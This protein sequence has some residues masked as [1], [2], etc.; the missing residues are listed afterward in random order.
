LL[1]LRKVTGWQQAVAIAVPFLLISGTP[2]PGGETRGLF[3]LKFFS[4]S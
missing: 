3:S 4:G 2:V 1:P